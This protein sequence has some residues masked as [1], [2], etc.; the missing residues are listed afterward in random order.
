MELSEI[1]KIEEQYGGAHGK[2][3]LGEAFQ[4]LKARWDTGQR[5]R[6]TCLRLLFLTWYCCSEPNEFTGLPGNV[7][8][9]GLFP[10]IFALL[11]DM[12][13]D[14]PEFL[15]VVG[16]MASLWSWCC[17]ESREWEQTGKEC[18]RRFQSSGEHLESKT[19]VGRGT[20][21]HYFAHIVESGW[22]EKCIKATIEGILGTPH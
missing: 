16:Y 8:T 7:N 10:S 14:D 21:G 12:T 17:G 11:N 9:A 2:P 20:Y 6:E 15:F 22:I 3:V 13:P 19:F 5:D 1:A 4:R 18:L